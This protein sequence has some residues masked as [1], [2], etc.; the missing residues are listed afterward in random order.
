MKNLI[1]VF[2]LCAVVFLVSC[3][4]FK[5]STSGQD[6]KT[7]AG[8]KGA[9]LSSALTVES[10]KADLQANTLA[11]NARQLSF[12]GNKSGEGYFSI[13]GKKMI[14]QSERQEGNPFYQM[15][16][17]DLAS[18]KS[19]RLSP[20]FGKTTCGWIHPNLQ[21]ALWSSTHLDKGFAEK[22]KQELAERAKPVKGRYSWSFDEN[23]D[24]FVSDLKGG[25]VKQ[26]TH[27]KGYDAEASFSND[28]K[29]IAFASNRKGYDHKLD[30]ETKKLFDQDP[31]YLMDIYIMKSD[32]SEVKQLTTT[33]GYD[34]G[35]FFSADS[36]KIT[37]RRFAP[38]GATAEI[39]TMN[40][41][42]SDQ[43]RITNMSVMSWAPY[44]HPSGEYIIFT[45]SLMGYSNFELFI[46]DVEGKHKPVRV[47]FDEGFD[48]LPSFS[49][50]GKKLTWTHRN[51]KGESQIL[52]A[53]W[54]H[55]Q[56]RYLLD[57][58]AKPISQ[59]KFHSDISAQDLQQTVYSLAN[60]NLKGR[61]T[62][63]EHESILLDDLQKLFKSW[64]FVGG[65]KSGF[66][67]KFQFTAGVKLKANNSLEA[68]GSHALNFK[69]EQDFV[70]LSSSKIGKQMAAPVVFAGYGLQ[71]PLD[72]KMPAY[73]SFADQDVK[74][75]WLLELEDAP[76]DV[77][78][79]L[80]HHYSLYSRNSHK[81]TVA[82]NLGAAGVIFIRPESG[83]E[84]LQL[85]YE[86]S[87][88]ENS[89][90]VLRISRAKAQELMKL[91]GLAL[92][93]LQNKLDK[94]EM[95]APVAL[96]GTYL[97]AEVN[98]EFIKKEARNFVAKLESPKAKNSVMIGAHGD[99]LGTGALGNS[100]AK[101]Q[102]WGLVHPGADDNASG[103]AAL[104]SIA[105]SFSS[106]KRS[107]LKQN[108]YFAIWSGEEIGILGSSIYLQEEKPKLS[109]YIN[110]DMIGRLRNRLLI[111]GV[112]SAR[113]WNNYIEEIALR[114]GLSI[115][116]QEDPYQPTDSMAFYNAK[117]PSVTF[118][119]GAHG[120]YHTPRDTPMLINYPA[121]ARVASAVFQLAKSLAADEQTI[122]KYQSVAS[123]GKQLD[124]RSFR[125][126]LGTIP[127]YTQESGAGVKVSG[128]TAGSPAD[129][130][131][132]K[133]NDIIL[134]FN[135]TK[136]ENIYDYVYTLQSV[137]PNLETD[138]KVKRGSEVLVLKITPML[139]Q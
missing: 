20:G 5:Q 71:V 137:K 117:I 46:V 82:K 138:I 104:V 101:P 114:T 134:E 43:K 52:I 30:P 50:D 130:A 122:L 27:E 4:G 33:P 35:P 72:E 139:K 13:D 3:Q 132:I 53:D 61:P 16:V 80:R 36:K 86:G 28:G 125:V 108:L 90:F 34:G 93:D 56:A 110:M 8:V 78:A 113:S 60:P 26:L 37:W 102:E 2:V 76:Q 40:I 128:A 98:L 7:E 79:D 92:D 39:Y 65:T 59:I 96:T 119:T 57:L 124:G 75:K 129:K 95:V 107:D 84:K 21:Q 109:A 127:D 15:Y 11:T 120:E 115:S 29:W 47:T 100:L 121:T 91:S 54:D 106:V 38:N 77:S 74:G 123:Q 14:F 81:L 6:A 19:T 48:G 51:E 83:D 62:A 31:S 105:K 136:I 24:I 88:L 17:M 126:Y 135:K 68:K 25:H 23:Y 22:V 63:G 112:G 99:H 85:K 10:K 69:L 66:I 111:Q 42:G 116:V 67:H 12:V 44:F 41:D 73:N 94:G 70:P 49:P 45:S 1:Q 64:G 55:E 18:G 97:E 103:V 131:G 87:M 89:I 9:N 118:F 32:G 133:E 58:S